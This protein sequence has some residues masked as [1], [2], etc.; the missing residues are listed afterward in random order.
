MG[1]LPSWLLV[2]ALG[3]VAALAAADAIRPT[4][5]AQPVPEPTQTAAPELRGVLLVG[6]SDCSVTALRLPELTQEQPPR[7]P[8]CGGAVW[9]ADGTL[10]A[11]CRDGVTVVRD[12]HGEPFRRVRGCAPAWNPNGFVSVIR[13]GNL[14]LAR[15]VFRPVPL[16]TRADVADQLSEVEPHPKRYE[17]AAVAW[18]DSSAFA[19]VVRR[20]SQPEDQYVAIFDDG[21]IEAAVPAFGPRISALRASRDGKVALGRGEVV[22][23]FVMLGRDGDPLPLPRVADARAIAWSPDGRWVALATRTNVFIARTGTREFVMRV[24]V[25]G[26][27]LEWLP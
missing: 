19:A 20:R 6:G 11:E 24:P 10:V 27:S 22:R 16:L 21:R 18:M 17:L 1:R 25:G 7:A 26:E 3:V 14:F 23:E 8:D 5:D 13:A 2:A 12:S 9:S 15:S 4:Q